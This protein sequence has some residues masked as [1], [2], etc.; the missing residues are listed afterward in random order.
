MSA[1]GDGESHCCAP[2]WGGARTCTP[3]NLTCGGCCTVRDGLNASSGVPCDP[4]LKSLN[5][6][7][8]DGGEGHATRTTNTSDPDYLLRE[9]SQY[10]EVSTVHDNTGPG[11][12]QAPFDMAMAQG[13]GGR[14]MLMIPSLNTTVVSFGESGPASLRCW[15]GYDDA[16]LVS[17]VW[18]AI[19]PAFESLIAGGG[20][21]TTAPNAEL[22]IAPKK[23]QQHEKP[24]QPPAPPMPQQREPEHHDWPHPPPPQ[25][26]S[27]FAGS[28]SCDCNGEGFGRCFNVPTDE[29][30]LPAP[31]APP[32]KLGA[33]K[34]MHD[35]S[36]PCNR[37][38]VNSTVARLIAD[39]A[40]DY[41]PLI[42]KT[43]QCQYP[44][45]AGTNLCDVR[46]AKPDDPPPS[47]MC[48]ALL[49]G[50]CSLA[51][52]SIN[53]TACND[54]ILDLRRSNA[55]SQAD[56]TSR[57]LSNF[58]RSHKP[59]A[60]KMLRKCAPIEGISDFFAVATCSMHPK[61]EDCQW[62]ASPCVYTPYFPPGKTDDSGLKVDMVEPMP[63]EGDT[64]T[65]PPPPPCKSTLDCCG[66]PCS[67]GTC[68]CSSGYTGPTC[69]ALNLGQCSVAVHPNETWTWGAA[70]SWDASTPSG[71]EV[72]AM[73]L[74][75]RCGINNYR[76]NAEI[77]RATSTSP[78]EPFT[79][80]DNF[81]A[82]APPR[83]DATEVEDPNVVELPA[84]LGGGTL[85]F[86]TGAWIK[87]DAALDCT[88]GDKPQPDSVKLGNA[89][90][91]GVAF[92]KKGETVW[93]RS[94]VPILSTRA[95]KWDS[96]RVS[97]PA[98]LVF[99]NGTM[100]LA[101]RGNGAKRG[102]I[103]VAKAPHWSGPYTHLYNQPLFNGYA[104][105]PTLY[106]G[107]NGVIHMIAHGELQPAPL[108]NVG[109]HS[110][111]AD[112]KTWNAPQV[113]YTL[114]ANWSSDVPSPPA[115][116][117]REAPQMLLS[118]DGKRPAA[119][120]NAAMPCKCKYGQPAL[121][122]VL[123]LCCFVRPHVL[124]RI[125]PCDDWRAMWRHLGDRRQECNWGN[126][127]RSFSMMCAVVPGKTDDQ[128]VRPDPL[129]LRYPLVSDESRLNEYRA[130]I[131]SASVVGD[132]ADES[133]LQAAAA[134]L[135]LG[136]S[137]L[138]GKPINVACCLRNDTV[139]A[140]KELR[141]E[142][143]KSAVELGKE[144]FR[145]RQ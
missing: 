106:L 34:P 23:G 4:T 76:Y 72:M 2:R 82:G 57:Q 58:C 6:N 14:Y 20:A 129:W 102:G 80:L 53:Y 60:A 16:W 114:F 83:F 52:G 124:P 30:P 100:L 140:A 145:I 84:S 99:P 103:G 65:P 70:P 55:S 40:A 64:G 38:P 107:P 50:A 111:S 94:A 127:C 49:K 108:F 89:Q 27:E 120:Y 138:L 87:G 18:N 117:R 126:A 26:Q 92:R 112:G 101:Y 63:A 71:V 118:R 73:G 43:R 123:A 24:Q 97:N 122:L 142:V 17:L 143:L 90:R 39:R 135:R 47:A 144:G 5:E 37:L 81:G 119:L 42:G 88:D 41:C 25:L 85:L 35:H 125:A 75:N 3:D 45:D 139:S 10:I 77:L 137:G 46:A 136:L 128:D 67:S 115:L 54:C 36:D 7:E 113:A 11:V 141:I 91:I 66:S 131:E 98:A 105:D 29:A 95:G 19:A 12:V 56:C 59:G 116:G 62:S 110:V 33:R 61:F 68:A 13:S 9:S 44:Q 48:T 28:C 74:R 96:T 78:F 31:P 109:V 121:S 8:V 133:Q 15:N 69:C 51:L 104:E 1:W 79:V 134:E 86:Y 132:S 130:Q 32:P 21:T 22:E 93:N